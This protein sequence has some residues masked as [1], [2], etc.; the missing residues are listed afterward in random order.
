MG[1]LISSLGGRNRNQ[2][3]RVEC[4]EGCCDRRSYSDDAFFHAGSKH[5]DPKI[6]TEKQLRTAHGR[7]AAGMVRAIML[8]LFDRRCC[9]I[10]YAAF[11]GGLT[12]VHLPLQRVS[13]RDR[14]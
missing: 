1:A 12:I 13:A 14:M 3:L 10:H 5:G 9:M 7:R 11:M 4:S 2:V 6:A 8:H